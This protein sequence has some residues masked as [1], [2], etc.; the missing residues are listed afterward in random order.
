MSSLA[1]NFGLYKNL[2]A[3]TH[4]V[5]PP[6]QVTSLV[7]FSSPFPLALTF[8]TSYNRVLATQ[9]MKRERNVS[10]TAKVCVS[11]VV[12]TLLQLVST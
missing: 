10:L 9:G 6:T 7:I 3:Y 1:L 11:R 8:I 12:V 2:P 4:P 5:Y